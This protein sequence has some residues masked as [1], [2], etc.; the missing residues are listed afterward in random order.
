MF[1]AVA[2]N[3]LSD[4]YLRQGY[5]IRPA[6]DSEALNWIR[7]QFARLIREN[8]SGHEDTETG[9]LLNR[10]HQDVPVAELNAFRL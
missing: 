7:D 9:A 8:L 3:N 5:V 10:F 1:F 6:A 2:E 4:E